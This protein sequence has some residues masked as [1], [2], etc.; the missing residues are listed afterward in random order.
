M[1]N[2]Y[3]TLRHVNVAL[4]ALLVAAMLLRG[5]AFLRANVASKFGRLTVFSW[6]SM[7]GYGTLE[8]LAQDAPAGPRVPAFTS[9]LL[10]TAWWV[11]VE[12]AYD[13]RQR[14]HLAAIVAAELARARP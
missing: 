2:L 9:V 3:E 6:V 10:I 1:S 13:R 5:G 14:A 12:I 4:S 11:A 8:T 7:T